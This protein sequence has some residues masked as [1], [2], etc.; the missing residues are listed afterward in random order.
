MYLRRDARQSDIKEIPLD[1]S[2]DD[3]DDGNDDDDNEDNDGYNNNYDDD[4]DNDNDGDDGNSSDDDSDTSDRN[5]D[6]GYGDDVYATK[7]SYYNNTG[8]QEDYG[9]DNDN[10]DDDDE[11]DYGS[12]YHHD[13]VGDNNGFAPT[14]SDAC[15]IDP[16][17]CRVFRPSSALPQTP[18]APSTYRPASAPFVYHYP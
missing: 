15:A 2:N 8:D 16:G 6:D 5:D 18:A 13:Y 17:Y 3:S 11:Y 4:D 1:F 14:T 7:H 9:S 10:D 12:Q